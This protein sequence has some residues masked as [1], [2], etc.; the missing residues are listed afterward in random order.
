MRCGRGP[1]ALAAS[2]LIADRDHGRVHPHPRCARAQ[3]EIDRRRPAAQRAR[4]DHRAVRLRQVL[5]RVR[6]HLRRRP[7]P[8]RREPLGVC[9]P[10]PRADAEARR[11]FDHRPVA[12]D[13]DRAEDHVRRTRA[14][15][16]ARSPRSTTTCA[17]S[18]PG[19]ASPIRPRP[20]CRSRARRCRR[21]S[22]ASWPCP[23]ARASICW[24]RSCAGAR[25]STAR[26]SPS[27]CAP[28]SSGSRSTASCTSW[29][30]CRSSTRRSS[31]TSSWWSIAWCWRPGSSS[32][33]PTRSRPR[34]TIPTVCSWSRMRIP[35]S[36][37]CSR[38]SSPARS[39]ASPSRR[40]SRACSRST[41]RR[42]P[43]RR[44]TV[45][46]A[47]CTWTRSWW[48]PIRRRACTTARSSPGRTRPRP[49][50]SR[51]STASRSAFARAC[52]RRGRSCLARCAS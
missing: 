19:S 36:S 44:A 26:S 27:C 16:S 46:G 42:A 6:H 4:G 41:A 43:A 25:A 45:S 38:P 29:T 8:L 52:T 12:G 39:P 17:C 30:R 13:R 40:S 11:R 49:T 32:A 24:R 34:C 5:A 50:T 15:R 3:S 37:C 20:G 14:R 31:T 28:A 35:A 1:V 33:W 22:T 7:A 10:V 47:A 48:C 2:R 23:R 18:T 51:P 9:P 21:W